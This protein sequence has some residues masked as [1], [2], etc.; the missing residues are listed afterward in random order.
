[1]L[2]LARVLVEVEV[3]HRVVRDALDAVLRNLRIAKPHRH[4]ELAIEILDEIGGALRGF[5]L[6]QSI[7]DAER[8]RDAQIPED[9]LERIAHDA[10]GDFYLHQNARKV[11]AESELVEL[12]KRMW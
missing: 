9:G 7:A 1:M 10:M 2:H 12:L 3:T 4:R 11:K 8:L 6:A 5:T